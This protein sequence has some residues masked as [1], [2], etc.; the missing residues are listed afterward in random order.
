MTIGVKFRR[1]IMRLIDADLLKKNVAKW[2][3][4]GDPQET[5]MV[6]LDDI[7]VSV[8]MEI[9]EQPTAYDVEKVIAELEKQKSDLTDWAEDKAFEIG[10][11]KA[12]EIVREEVYYE[13]YRLKVVINQSGKYDVHDNKYGGKITH[14]NVSKEQADDRI[15]H[16]LS[17]RNRR[18]NKQ[19]NER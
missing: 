5:V 10:I 16:I 12:I 17:V 8:I 3:Q 1:L 14:K 9:E 15:Q 13:D 19:K 7:A 6:E 4:G 11:E 18:K 2:L